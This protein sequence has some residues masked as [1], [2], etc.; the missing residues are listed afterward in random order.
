MFCLEH[1]GTSATEAAGTATTEATGAT[2]S[3]GATGAALHLLAGLLATE[4]VQAVAD[5]EQGVGV[6]AVILRVAAL[7]G[8]DGAAVVALLVE[9]VVQLQA[10]GEWL[11]LEKALRDLC[12]PD[13]LVGVHRAVG[14]APSA[15]V[16]QIGGE[17]RTPRSIDVE[18]ATVGELPCVEVVLRLQQV[19][20]VHVVE[21]TI[22][23]HLYPVL[24]PAALQTLH[25]ARGACGVLLR[26]HSLAHVEV[27]HVVVVVEHGEGVDV[28]YGGRV[29]GG[30]EHEAQVGVP[31]A[32]DVLRSSGASACCCVV[33]DEV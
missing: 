4:E 25:D 20:R 11:A 15:L 27:A 3:T 9:D 17:A 8:V 5:V 26:A 1:P 22:E 29:D 31:V 24:S 14:I 13:E 18:A 7:H 19:L 30:V 16:V 10:D 21:R 23:R 33:G 12:I 32:V 28:P 2:L 6:D